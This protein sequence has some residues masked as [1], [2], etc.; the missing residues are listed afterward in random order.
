MSMAA[1]S[2]AI[3][4]MPD[5]EIPN[6]PI[7]QAPPTLDW[8]E[9]APDPVR[10]EKGTL[11]PNPLDVEIMRRLLA[12][13]V[14]PVQCQARI[15]AALD[16]GNIAVYAARDICETDCTAG[17]I[18]MDAKTPPSWAWWEIAIAVAGS[19]LLGV[20]TGYLAGY[21]RLGR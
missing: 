11:L 16:Y 5:P 13:E 3:S 15:N 8:S 4:I 1:I 10:T 9:N 12:Y 18:I 17:T 19:T 20:G 7:L 14:Y 2:L 6:N 21:T